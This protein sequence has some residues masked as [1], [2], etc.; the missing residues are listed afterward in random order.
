VT[1]RTPRRT[2]RQAAEALRLSSEV[3][4]HVSD[5]IVVIRASDEMI[6][7]TNAPFDQMFGYRSGELL[8]KH[9]AIVNAPTNESPEE[10]ARTIIEELQ[11]DGRWQGEVCNRRKDGTPFWCHIS[12]STFTHAEFGTVWISVNRDITERRR[13]NEELRES[14]RR[15]S[16]AFEHAPVAMA[17]V[18]LDGH[19]LRVNLAMCRM[20]G[21]GREEMLAMRPWD[22]TQPEDMLTTLEHLKQMVVGETDSWQLEKRYRHKLGH[23]VWGLSDTSIVRGEDG[24]PLYV[25]SQVQN[26][27]ERRHA[28]Q[29]RRRHERNTRIVNGILRV[30]NTHLEL[31]AVFPE[32]CAGLRDLAG[33]AT[34][35]LN[36]FD[37]SRKWISLVANEA[38]WTI[39]VGQD[40]RLRTAEIPFGAE[41]LAGKP[42]VVRDM[43]TEAQY[44]IVQLT[45]DTLGVRSFI[46]LPLCADVVVGFLNLF[47]REVDGCQSGE[48]GP[49]TQVANAVAIAVE[50]SRLFEEVRVGH[51]RLGALSQQLMEVQEVERRHL[52]RELHDEVGQVLT[53][54]KF[55]LDG[56]ER[57]PHPA[58]QV[59]LRDAKQHL[60]DLLARVRSLSL[61]LRPAMLDDLGLLA[62]VIWLVDRYS[63]QSKVQVRIE[64]DGLDRR[65]APQI[66]TGAYRIVQEALTNAVRHAGAT[67][68]TVRLWVDDRTLTIQ[69][70]DTGK[71]FDPALASVDRSRGG[72][73]GMRERARL[74]GGN[75]T[76]ESALGAGTRVIAQLPV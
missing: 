43:T 12:V 30:M 59:R 31:K 64:H 24:T 1:A 27:T 17:L 5:G 61:D 73:L 20:L 38:P 54:L 7:F 74:L 11:G 15:F 48:M 60:D 56:I 33:C 36:L 6:V 63:H 3:L 19:F 41:I 69:I 47:W 49:L 9:V 13:V 67:Q 71:G 46:S 76:V 40:A 45:C 10:I 22:L 23:E 2:Q 62:A 39:G 18:T 25:I 42:V 44:P 58:G 37:E 16:T 51:E 28:E 29:I 55:M 32:V 21:Y 52:A 65:F 68:V 72:V 53:A 35:T 34:V 8:G 50:K 75:L 66:E 26:I 70:I 4:N 14:E 57:M